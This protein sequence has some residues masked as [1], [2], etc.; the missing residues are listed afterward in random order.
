MTDYDGVLS[1]AGIS[2]QQYLSSRSSFLV[3]LVPSV[4]DAK[5][6]ADIKKDYFKSYLMVGIHFRTHDSK[7]DWEVVPPFDSS[8]SARKFGDGASTED[9]VRIMSA[10][11]ANFADYTNMGISTVR[12][13]VASN[14]EKAKGIHYLLLVYV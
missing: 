12:F 13:F 7:Q 8:P 5:F 10:I 2:C 3:S 9:F 4:E 6:V 11:K 1:L 14:S